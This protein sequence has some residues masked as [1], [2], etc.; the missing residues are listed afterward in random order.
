MSLLKGVKLTVGEV[1]DFLV[2][3]GRHRGLLLAEDLCVEAGVVEVDLAVLVHVLG[4][5][6][7]QG[8]YRV[9]KPIAAKLAEVEFFHQVHRSERKQS[10]EREIT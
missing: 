1:R 7:L 5:V 10:A 4:D 8:G 2:L 3:V 6:G 9:R